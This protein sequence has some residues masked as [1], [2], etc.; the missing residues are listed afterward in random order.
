MKR[1]FFLVILSAVFIGCDS[2]LDCEVAPDI[3]NIDVNVKIDRLEDILFNASS[4]KDIEYFLFNNP[5]LTEQFLGSNQYPSDSILAL[6]L[7]KN[8]KH[9]SLDTLYQETKTVFG[10]GS[11][12]EEQLSLAFS[13]IKYYY[14]DFNAP[15]VQTMVTGFGSSEIFVSDS[16]VVIGLDYYLGEQAKFRPNG[17]PDYILKRFDKAYIVPAI[18]LLLTDKYVASFSSDNTMLAEMLYFGKRFYLAKK[19]MPCVNDSLIIWYDGKE[20]INVE[21]NKEV[22]WHHFL[23]KQLLFE[24]NHMVKKKY[25]E[26]RPKVLEIGDKC[27]GRIGTWLGWD[28]V[29]AYMEQKPEISVQQLMMINNAQEIFNGSKYRAK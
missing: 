21:N 3:S 4:P 23:D 19:T 16:L 28:I 17:F 25:I 22:L 9:P 7:Y 5:V 8:V 2:D 27:P 10:D 24:S 11:E 18:V 1:L 13:Y 20:L 12:L 26:E 29:R 6:E 15:K 14:P